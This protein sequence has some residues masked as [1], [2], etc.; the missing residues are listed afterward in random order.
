MK[1][2]GS[3]PCI[4]VSDSQGDLILD[5]GTGIVHVK[6]SDHKAGQPYHIL[7]THL[8]MDHIQGLGFFQPLFDP[9]SEVHI[10]GPASSTDSLF[11]R[12]RR[13]LSP[14]LFPVSL[15]D[16]PCKLEVHDLANAEFSLADFNIM[17]RFV[18]HPGPTIGYRVSNQGKVL[19]YIP[20]HEP[21][22]GS[23]DL[24]E[25]TAWLSGYDLVKDCDLLIHDGQYT[26]SRYLSRVGWGHSSMHHAAELAQKCGAKR[27]LIF[28]HDPSNTDEQLE[29]MFREFQDN[30]T[31]EFP[32][33]LAKQDSIIE[34]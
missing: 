2:G 19:T 18:S 6:K 7:L 5:A 10:W 27:L 23:T 30:H 14:P 11:D 17:T 20:D 3:T 26:A 22:I 29:A 13:F 32:I 9:E 4:Q 33:E 25:D 12:L 8:H 16:V 34:L 28:H 21:I 24:Y 31:Y 1:Y 15:R